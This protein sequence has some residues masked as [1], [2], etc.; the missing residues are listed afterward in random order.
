MS[1]TM[2]FEM[3]WEP[4]ERQFPS[5]REPVWS[6]PE[7]RKTWLLGMTDQELEN[8]SP[9]EKGAILPAYTWDSGYETYGERALYYIVGSQLATAAHIQS[10][11]TKAEKIRL[12]QAI[13]DWRDSRTAT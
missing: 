5:K 7:W 11:L 2:D 1:F 9:R 4:E 12:G 8:M 13:L 6:D 3:E 10:S